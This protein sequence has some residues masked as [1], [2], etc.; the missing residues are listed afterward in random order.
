MLRIGPGPSLVSVYR[1]GGLACETLTDC[2]AIPMR[3][4]CYVTHRHT[5]KISSQS[6][7]TRD[8]WAVGPSWVGISMQCTSL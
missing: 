4:K 6:K 8:F 3:L 1:K 7:H 5:R 2:V